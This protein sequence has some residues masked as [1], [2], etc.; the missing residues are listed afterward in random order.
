M[1]RQSVLLIYYCWGKNCLS[2]KIWVTQ[3]IRT[4]VCESL[5]FL[6]TFFSNLPQSPL[7]V[8]EM[9]TIRPILVYFIAIYFSIFDCSLIV[10]SFK[11]DECFLYS[12]C[13]CYQTRYQIVDSYGRNFKRPNWDL[14]KTSCARSI[15]IPQFRKLFARKVTI[16]LSSFFAS[17]LPV[18]SQASGWQCVSVSVICSQLTVK[19]K[20]VSES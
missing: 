11:C 16:I 10:S 4:H 3:E 20:L 14:V 13:D 18:E 6:V 2:V 7:T 8:K 17:F 1:V 9:V 5:Y 19:V 12:F 15:S